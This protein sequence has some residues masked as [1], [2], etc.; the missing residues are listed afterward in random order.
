VDGRGTEYTVRLET[1]SPKGAMGTILARSRSFAE[2]PC[3]I[4]LAQ[5][6]P[7]G[8]KM[9]WIVKAVTELGVTRV[10]PLLTERCVVRLEPGRWRDRA[11]RWQR[12]AKEAAKQCGRSVIPSIELPRPLTEFLD[13]RPAADLALCLWEGEPRG[14]REIVGFIE[15]RIG[16][17]LLVVGPEGGLA[18][19]EVE[20]SRKRGFESASLGPRILRAET[21]GPAAVS[22]L[23]A[24]FG[25][26][27][28]TRE[29]V[30]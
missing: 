7:K 16:S 5:A 29:S 23:Q 17:A 14:L 15:V 8:E 1:I 24:R 12:V 4:T 21:A 28:A 30:E 6:V 13:E 26:L 20:A 2:S 11:R 10:L 25:D 3:S 22:I 27:G 19:G 9:E 18:P